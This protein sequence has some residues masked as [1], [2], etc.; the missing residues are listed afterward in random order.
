[1]SVP[2]IVQL[3]IKSLHDLIKA[4]GEA[5][6]AAEKNLV[7]KVT[8]PDL[9]AAL[10]EK[11][12]V[13]EL[14]K[15]LEQLMS[16]MDN[17]ADARDTG[18][19]L[20]RM[21]TRHDVKRS[22]A[23]KAD[24]HTVQQ[25]LDAKAD[26]HEAQRLLESLGTLEERL[27]QAESR[28]AET[29][30]AIAAESTTRQ[31]AAERR[32]EFQSLLAEAVDALRVEL[33]AK[34]SRET[35]AMALQTKASRQEMED[36][37]AS[38][39]SRVHE[40]LSSQLELELAAHAANATS[41]LEAATRALS[42]RITHL[43]SPPI[44]Y[45]QATAIV[46]APHRGCH[47]ITRELLEAIPA[48]VDFQTGLCNLFVQHTACSLSVNVVDDP[49]VHEDLESAL[50]KIVPVAWVHDGTFK[51]TIPASDRRHTM[52]GHIKSALMGASLTIPVSRGTLALG[53]WQGIY[54]HEHRDH[55]RHLS[56][57]GGAV[58]RRSV[59]ITVQGEL[60]E[61]SRSG[62]FPVYR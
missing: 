17:K 29:A 11:V 39:A 19:V 43:T 59:V 35:V 46:S 61:R 40:Q 16:V 41:E 25:C 58:H 44:S 18:A 33:S 26:A 30:A 15:S 21:A 20:Q 9:T 3:N 52:P 57:R 53:E 55:E 28:I 8:R 45:A 34:A 51:R 36:L 12:S 50:D 38:E 5:L 23:E 32:S 27:E 4:Q 56:G 7:N 54:L 2:E 10:Q 48:L 60:A 14:T 31:S 1:M 13:S 42:A 6:K 62:K 37:V 47:L 49:T 24:L 22:L